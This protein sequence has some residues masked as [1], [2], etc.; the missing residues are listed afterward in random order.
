METLQSDI[1]RLQSRINS[2]WFGKDKLIDEYNQKVNQYN[3][4]LQSYNTEY[5]EYENLL[6]EHNR[7]VATHDSL[8]NTYNSR[9]RR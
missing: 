9:I 6:K 7:D 1:N 4:L 3:Y 8:V 5:Y 2:A